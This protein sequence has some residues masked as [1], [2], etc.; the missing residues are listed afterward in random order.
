MTGVHF[1]TLVLRC[2]DVLGVAERKEREKERRREDIVN[3]AAKVF[4]NKGVDHATMDDV[5]EAAE[6]SK[7][8]L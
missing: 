5:A 1:V 4:F 6:L 7:A 3:A 8:T 2:G